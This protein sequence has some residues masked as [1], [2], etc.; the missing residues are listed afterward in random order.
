ME[1]L[2]VVMGRLQGEHCVHGNVGERT[3]RPALTGGISLQF[4]FDLFWNCRGQGTV[5][6]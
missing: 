5:Q 2:T 4:Q 6:I 1:L 3:P